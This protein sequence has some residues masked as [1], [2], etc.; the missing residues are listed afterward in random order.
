MQKHK[1]NQNGLWK[2]GT[3]NSKPLEITNDNQHHLT[4]T[5]TKKTFFFT[6]YLVLDPVD[7]KLQMQSRVFQKRTRKIFIYKMEI[8]I[9]ILSPSFLIFRKMSSGF[10][11][12]ARL[13]TDVL[14]IANKICSEFFFTYVKNKCKNIYEVATRIQER[15][16][17]QETIFAPAQEWDGM[18]LIEL[19]T[20]TL[21]KPLL[22]IC[23][24]LVA[25][26]E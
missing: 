2:K 8:C 12:T 13:S 20:K 19:H 16:V 22:T 10:T 11:I 21:D 25:R 4:L 9:I 24:K 5:T 17:T 26:L 7:R 1:K 14:S 15:F 6:K 3:P 18:A 23:Y